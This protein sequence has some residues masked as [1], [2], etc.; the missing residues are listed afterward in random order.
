MK[1]FNQCDPQWAGH[2]LGWSAPGTICQYGCLESDFAAILNDTGH[3]TTPP[4][5]DALLDAKKLYVKDSTGTYDLLADNTLDKLYPGEYVTTSYA[6]FRADIIKAAVPSADTYVILFI[7]G[8]SPLWKMNVVTHF[9]LGWTADGSIIGD[10]EGGIPRA[11]AGYGGSANVH[12]TM[13]VKHIKPAPAP[14]PPPPAPAPPPPP[15]VYS[16]SQGNAVLATGLLYDAAVA[17]AKAFAASHVGLL[18]AVIDAHG[19][20]VD[21]E[22]VAPPPA[23]V[24][25]VP[26]PVPT[27]LPNPPADLWS[28][29]SFILVQIVLFIRRAQ[30]QAQP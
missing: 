30:G 26:S 18:F 7:S 3:P 14:P 21:T 23:P 22:F 29:I 17:Q 4:A 1:L 28:V 25:P 6:G 2:A 19:A 27:P 12:K 15:P 9:V 10:P 5:L 8:Y 16:V 20:T 11:L 13:T 24:P